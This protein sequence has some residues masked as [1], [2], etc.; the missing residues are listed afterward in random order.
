[1][2]EENSFMC[3]LLAATL[4]EGVS[5]I[6]D[7]TINRLEQDLARKHPSGANQLLA[8]AKPWVIPI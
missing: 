2:I 5:A 4:E 3:F 7:E 8:M 6:T 1:M